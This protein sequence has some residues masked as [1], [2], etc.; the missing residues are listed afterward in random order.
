MERANNLFCRRCV[1]LN[2]TLEIVQVR[3]TF[4]LEN[5]RLSAAWG[6]VF[7][8]LLVV[9][10]FLQPNVAAVFLVGAGFWWFLY[11]TMSRLTLQLTDQAV[12]LKGRL[13][14]VVRRVPLERI[15]GAELAFK[16]ELKLNAMA[17]QQ[18]V[19]EMHNPNA[20]TNKHLFQKY[21]EQAKTR[22]PVSWLDTSWLDPMD[23]R[24]RYTV[25]GDYAVVFWV[26]SGWF[27]RDPK[28]FG[29]R[30]SRLEDAAAF[31]EAFKKVHNQRDSLKK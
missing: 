18:M 24:T 28:A 9:F 2:D 8:C 7:T 6:V 29:I 14:F 19:E 1:S 23:S 15:K 22:N 11:A 26:K 30:F 16:P 3:Y 21:L 4:E 10:A 25:Q 5:Y 20:A 12:V 13:G 17:F 27:Q 31:F